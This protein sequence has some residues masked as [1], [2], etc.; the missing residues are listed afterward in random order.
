MKAASVPSQRPPGA[1]LLSSDRSEN[2]QH[3]RRSQ[4]IDLLGP[5]DLVIA[6]DAATLPSSL[7]GHHLP[8]GRAI[9]IRLA[10][11]DSLHEVQVFSA[12]AFGEGDYRQR[13]EDRPDPPFFSAGDSLALGP[14]RATVLDTLAHPRFLRL[15]FEGAAVDIREGLARHGRPVQYSHIAEPLAVWDTWTPIAGPPVAFEPP[16]A[17]FILNWKLLNDLLARGVRFATITHA[18]GL[19]STGDPALD[20]LLPLPEPY[21]IPASTALSIRRARARGG[22]IIA[23]GTTVVRALEHSAGIFNGNVP[24]GERIATQRIDASTSLRVVDAIVSGTHEPGTSHYDL[25][26]AFASDEALADIDQQLNAYDYRTHEF[27]D[28]VFIEN[29]RRP[30]QR[31]VAA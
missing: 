20:A 15:K 14:L 9:E 21:R 1:K 19:S 27:G 11:R 22:R 13:T 18:A 2:V 29:Q 24:A 6:N 16:S 31:S 25:L 12:V 8:T 4:F 17:G 28:S 5:D 30:A 26:H 7:S 10:G 23:I 3:L